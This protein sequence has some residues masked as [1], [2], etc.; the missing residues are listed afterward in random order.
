MGLTIEESR[1]NN[2]RLLAK[3]AGGQSK[4]AAKLGKSRQLI[5]HYIGKNPIKKIGSE[6]ARE[7]E[8]AIGLGSGWMDEFHATQPSASENSLKSGPKPVIPA[9]LA[10]DVDQLI[11]HYL[12]ASPSERRAILRRAE[13]AATRYLPDSS[14]N[15]A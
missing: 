5:N 15:E 8:I 6:M 3:E 1:V 4:L 10:K 7:I 12:V 9:L 2:A 11:S 14:D 13:R